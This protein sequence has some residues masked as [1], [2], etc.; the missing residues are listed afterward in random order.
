MNGLLNQRGDVYQYQDLETGTDGVIQSSYIYL[1][2]YWCR[3]DQVTGQQML[4]GEGAET[5]IDAYIAFSGDVFIP[6]QSVITVDGDDYLT[7]FINKRKASNQQIISGKISTNPSYVKYLSG[8]I[9]SPPSASITAPLSASYAATSSLLLGLVQSASYALTAQNVLGSIPSA[10]YALTASYAPTNNTGSF[11]GSFVGDGSKL[12][13][14]VS[15]SFAQSALTANSATQAS[16]ASLATSINFIPATASYAGTA[17]AI[18]FVPATASYATVAQSVLNNPI[19]ASFAQNALTAN[20]ATSAATASSINF[21]PVTASYALT[22][23]VALNAVPSV[24]ASYATTASYASVAQN[25][26]G[27]IT[28]ASFAQNALTANSATSA[29]T[30]SL[31][32]ALSFVPATASYATVAQSVLNVPATASYANTS[33]YA[34][35]VPA[36]G[37][38]GTVTSASFAQNALTANSATSA[39]SASFATT[40]SAATSITFTPATASYALTASVAL[41]AGGSVTSASYATTSS[42]ASTAQ[43]VLGSVTSASYASTASLLLGSVQS[44]SYASTAPTASAAYYVPATVACTIL[45][46]DF[47]TGQT[48]GT[49]GIGTIGW[50]ATNAVS[51]VANTAGH[52]GSILLVTTATS[53]NLGG[54]YS[55]TGK[56]NGVIDASNIQS[57]IAVVQ[58]SSSAATPFKARIGFCSDVSVQSAGSAA[59]L[60]VTD[61][62]L[63]HPTHWYCRCRNSAVS[64]DTDSGIIASASNWYQLEARRNPTTSTN[65][66]FFINNSYVTTV[67]SSLPTGQLVWGA[68][69]ETNENVAK[70]MIVDYMAME[71]TNPLG[72]RWT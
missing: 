28:S 43:T 26:L 42:F 53:G 13:G 50:N 30:A 58:M 1:G 34:A 16:T 45:Q 11:T 51:V 25:V 66:D 37:I 14:L 38:V 24:S 40:A 64:V 47:L 10:S 15:A 29:A 12:S 68:T 35:T 60:F 48:G 23:S 27:S 54:I 31:A 57:F 22:A 52:P 49:T 3:V 39:T 17:G 72:Q 44:A 41:N 21:T 5:H 20:S 67:S 36:S 6:E 4:V 33:S 65:W 18:N 61:S 70:Q 46:D 7:I 55:R 63:A 2:T 19:S 9:V 8:S 62:T 32:Q 59:V 69:L 56:S 71:T